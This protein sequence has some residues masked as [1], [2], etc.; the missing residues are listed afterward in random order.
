MTVRKRIFISN[1]VMLVILIML[2]LLLCFYIVRVFVSTY[3]TNDINSVSIPTSSYKSVSV[4]EL[5]I[6]FDSMISMGEE[7]TFSPEEHS[8]YEKIDAYL[9]GTDTMAY[10]LVDG[11]TVYLTGAQ[12]ADEIY[13][14]AVKTKSSIENQQGTLFY[15]N[16]SSFM[17]ATT[18]LSDEKEITIMM[19]NNQ[20]GTSG[21]KIDN[22]KYWD[23]AGATISRTVRSIAIMGGIVIVIVNFLLIIAVSNSIIGPLNKLKEA[24]KMV[25]EGKFDFELDYTGADELTDVIASFDDM[26]TKLLESTEQ[27]RRQE[28]NRKEMIAGIS[29]D[30]RTPLTSIKGYVSGLIDGIAESPERRQQYLK[31]IYNTACDLDKMVDELFLYSKLDMEKVPFDFIIMDINE[32]LL[33]CSEEFHF[34]YGKQNIVVT[35]TNL[36]KE[37]IYVSLDPDQFARVLINIADNSAKYKVN[38]VGSLHITLYSEDEDFVSISLKDDGNGVDKQFAEKIFDSFYRN[39]PA[40]TNPVKGSGLGL[41]IAKQIVLSHGGQIRAETNIGEGMNM[42]ITLPR[43]NNPEK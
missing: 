34:T 4:F 25:A 6:V 37:P 43:L 7:S 11:N 8:D 20:L 17:Y 2:V 26:R 36:C 35:Y 33:S 22:S 32:Y 27:Q 14:Y 13:K 19:F 5:Q 16:D 15:S 31:I 10:I 12:S 24:T 1:L 39:D 18:F 42:I 21:F 41:S 38:E 23:D 3:I 30:L 28:E 29:H 9:K 40:R